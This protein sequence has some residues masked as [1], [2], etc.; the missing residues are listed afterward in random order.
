[1]KLGLYA[2]FD[3]SNS[4]F[5]HP[6]PIMTPRFFH[7]RIAILLLLW[8]PS[9]AVASNTPEG[10]TLQTSASPVKLAA[11]GKALAAIVISPDSSEEL[12]RT[13]ANL[14]ETLRRITGAEFAIEESTEPAGITLGTLAQFPDES[15]KEPLAIRNTYD[16]VE[17]FAIRSDGGRVR[18]LGNTD[19]GASHAAARFLELIGYRAYFMGPDW[20]IVPELKT[21]AFDLNETSRPKVWSRRLG[22]TRMNIKGEEGDRDRKE[23]FRRWL[24]SNRVAQSL[25]LSTSHVWHAIPDAFKMQGFPFRQEFADHPEYFALVDGKRTPPQFCVT[26]P[27]LQNV[28]T[29]YAKQYFEINPTA[30]MVSLDTADQAN[31]CTCPECEKLGQP[32]DQAFYLANVVARELAKSH[33]G[34]YVGILAY[35]WHSDPPAFDL[36]PNVFVM[37]TAGM[38]ASKLSFEELFEAWTKKCKSIGIYEYFTY[39]EMDKGMLPGKGPHNEIDNL[40]ARYKRYVDNHVIG[41]M[42]ESANSWGT[43]GFGYYMATRLLWD[44]TT[45][46]EAL[47]KDFYEKAFG[48]AAPAMARYFE[49]LDLSHHPFR[50]VAQLRQ[51]LADL[52]EATALAK[53]RPDVLARLDDLKATLIYTY[54]GNKVEQADDDAQKELALEWF[55]WAYRIRNSYMIDWVTFRA[56]VGNHEYSRTLAAKFDEPGWNYRHSK[57]NPW[58]DDRPVTSGEIEGRLDAIEAEWGKVPE[59]KAETFSNDFVLV[60]VEGAPEGEQKPRSFMGTAAFLL[61]SP[62]GEPLKFK[63]TSAPSPRIERQDAKYSLSTLDGKILTSGDLPEGEN[64]MELKVPGPGIYKFSCKRGG[65]GWEIDLGES[66]PGAVIV[67]RGVEY[68]PQFMTT[69]FYVPKNKGNFVVYAQEGGMNIKT[70][71]GEQVYQGTPNGDFISVPVPDGMDGRVWSLTGKSRNVWFLDI[72]TVLASDPTRLFLP[73]EVAVKDGLSPVAM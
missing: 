41:F 32:G 22:F 20:E 31:W 15:L 56:A 9:F 42:A 11:E 67:E 30:D 47:K 38:N 1:M 21:L 19:L 51:C 64:T 55:K 14:A 35:S 70:P 16:G 17:A 39:W 68:R 53:S 24:T 37:L 18:L 58:R 5:S 44:P 23:D 54:L 61:A 29:R 46:V 36:E 63:I 13:A 26:N 3:L 27:G 66:V 40:P 60:E 7:R 69:Y 8:I 12:R 28:V 59:V 25:A 49:R 4:I 34:K 50:G 72:P 45:D 10:Q 6:L 62:K 73:R 48:P 71:D 57:E 52:R 65:R 33:P 43:H 2:I